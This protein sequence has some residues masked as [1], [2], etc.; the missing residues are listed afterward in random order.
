MYIRLRQLAL[1]AFTVAFLLAGSSRADVAPG[2]VVTKDNVDK[3][4]ELIS[5]GLE[6]CVR[7]GMQMKIVPYKKIEW[8][9]EFREA[10]EKYSSQV[11]LAA[12]GRSLEGHVAGLPFPK[13][14][15]N[16]P[17]L[18]L[19]IMWNYEYKPYVTDDE[20]LRNFDADTGPVGDGPMQVERHFLL[21][22]LRLLLYNGRLIVDPK[23][24]RPNPDQVRG[25]SSLHPI[26]EP[27]DLKGVGS[28]SI[29]YLNADRQDDTWLYL[30]TLRRVRRLS[31]AQRSDALF[32]QDTDVDSYGGYAGQ[33]PWFDWKY[34][35]EKEVL[36]SYHSENFPVK[37]CEGG[38]DFIFCDTWEKRKVWVVEGVSKLPQYAYGKRVLFIDQETYLIAFSDIY[39]RTG[40][41]WK[42]WVNQWSFKKRATGSYGAEYADEM[43][44][45]PSI[46]MV[47]MQLSHATRAALPS[48]KFPGEEGWYFNQ[49][50]KS[51]LTEEF[52]TIAHLIESGH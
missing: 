25:K 2:D 36:G 35:G 50:D 46:T 18:A 27:F 29:R 1:H 43:P 30:P 4:K 42:V 19:K 11:K 44:F 41:L 20:D 32:G 39:D 31:S 23:P 48:N 17:Q 14:D 47:D 34:L 52:F 15:A 24:T 10:T 28:T 33:I 22:H 49:G 5:P 8:N 45:Q 21:D 13:L 6:W 37:Y 40:N 12:D 3:V 38:G 7:H 9:R 26:L 16:D 51:G